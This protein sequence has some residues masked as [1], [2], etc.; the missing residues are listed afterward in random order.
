MLG[1]HRMR[2]LKGVTGG[3]LAATTGWRA[4][5]QG[6]MPYGACSPAEIWPGVPS[7]ASQAWIHQCAPTLGS[8]LASWMVKV[9]RQSCNAV[10]S[11]WVVHT[12]WRGALKVG[13]FGKPE[14]SP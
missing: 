8:A 9:A 7:G 10:G 2:R 13:P 12:A 4:F 14:R 6:S 5:L 1:R 3:N 11:T